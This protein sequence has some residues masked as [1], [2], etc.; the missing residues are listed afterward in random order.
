[1]AQV[2]GARLSTDSV[3][4]EVDLAIDYNEEVRRSGVDAASALERILRARGIQAVRSSV[5]V[6]CWI[7]AFDKL[8]D[9]AAVSRSRVEDDDC[10][11]TTTRC[12]YAGDSF[13]DA[14]MFGPSRCR[15]ASRTS[16][17]ARAH[18]R[19]A[20]VRRRRGRRSRVPGTRRRGAG[21]PT[22][23]GVTAR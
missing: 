21:C 1:M 20:E 10:A 4:T 11:A 23:A 17:G 5:H 9:G 2:H 15:W 19:A 7:G 8:L 3:Y 18:R 14:P 6:N 12:V 22:R 16:D 13:N